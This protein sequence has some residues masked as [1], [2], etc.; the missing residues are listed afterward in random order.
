[1]WLQNFFLFSLVWSFGSILKINLRREFERHIKTKIFSNT[2]EISQIAQL[3][4]KIVRKT[5]AGSKV[6]TDQN[7]LYEPTKEFK[8]PEKTPYF[9]CSINQNYS[10]FEIFFDLETNSWIHWDTLKAI[11]KPYKEDEKS[12]KKKQAYFLMFVPTIET[13]RL[14]YIIEANIICKNNMLLIGPTGCGKSWLSREVIFKQLPNIS[15]KYKA[16]S[17]VFS[18]NSTAEKTQHFID[19][20]LERRKKG[21]FGPPFS[22]KQLFFIDDLM[23]P[24]KDEYNIQSSNELLR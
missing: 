18:N 20:R 17:L 13:I 10:L 22:H 23:M 4:S 9:L 3:K 7:I 12:F 14:G 1:M 19:S 5:L 6:K 24:F 16:S 2:E 21:I 15:S 8:E 11:Q